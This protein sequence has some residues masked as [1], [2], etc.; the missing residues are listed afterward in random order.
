MTDRQRRC[1]GVAA[2]IAF[3]VAVGMAVLGA[4]PFA[5]QTVGPYDLL[6]ASKGWSQ[7]YGPVEVRNGERTDVLDAMVP[8]WMFARGELRQGRVP[9]WNPLPGGGEPGI[10]NL[11][12]SQLTPAFAIFAAAPSASSGFYLATLFNLVMA[13]LGAWFW[14][15]RSLGTLP[16]L[17]GGVT[18]MLCGFHAA[19]LYWPHMSTS[20]W[21]C[22]L[23]WSVE[24]W[25]KRPGAWRFA[26]MTL[27]TTLLLL[28]GFP[29]VA[30]LGLGAA[31]LYALVLWRMA[32]QPGNRRLAG[33]FGALALGA[34]L[35][36]I[37]LIALATWLAHIDT[38]A[39][40]G[41]SPLRL[42]TDAVRLLPHIARQS[43]QVESHMYV[44]GLG[45][46]LAAAALLRWI[47]PRRLEPVLVLASLLLVISSVLVF[48]LIPPAWLGWVPGLGGNGWARGILLL[49]IALAALAASALALLLRRIQRPWMAL[50]LT[51]PL[52]VV[53]VVDLGT[54]FRRFNGP[55]PAALM[56]PP[57][58]Q[59]AQVQAGLLPFTYVIADGNYLV[60]GTLGA[61][62]VPEWYG[63][64]FKTAAV[65]RLLAQAVRDPFTTPTASIIGADAIQLDSP[66][67][68]A[69]AVKYVL[70]DERLLAQAWVPEYPAGPA[71][72][73]A[74]PALGTAAWSQSVDLPAHFTLSD[75]ELRL[76]TYGGSGLHGSVTLSLLDPEK[77]GSVLA[78]AT[79]PAGSIVDG[80]M[81]RFHF[82]PAVTPAQQ[83]VVL[84]LRHEGAAANENITAWYR[85]GGAANCALQVEPA[86]APGCLILRIL[87]E[88]PGLAGWAVAAQAPGLVLLENRDAP[89]GAYFLDSLDQAPAAH[90]AEA[91]RVQGNFSD[92]WTL[93]YT[94]SRSGYVVLP[95]AAS[96]SWEFSVDGNR[97]QPQQYFGTLPAIAVQPGAVITARYQPRALIVGG[98]IMLGSVLLLVAVM[99][100][101]RRRRHAD[102]GSARGA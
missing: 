14:L 5:Q 25:W 20:V 49:D 43:P 23:L 91:V 94:G 28:G 82:A 51:V 65:K 29:F 53:Q 60:S 38:A 44:G 62:G 92:G 101:L 100:G 7:E 96:E 50:L 42:L 36:A 69:M 59:I 58:R 10:H 6:V 56:F 64:G 46:L 40:T 22:W 33:M 78:E 1:W 3:F 68:R 21:V 95:M 34:G 66:A 55:V 31:V 73:E 70:G 48:Q 80:E 37:P 30:Q 72:M 93:Q 89:A 61:Y 2:A 17:F 84:T 11:A 24:G 52:L 35:A 26:A 54:M 47:R 63:H 86:R 74:L 9:L 81:A 85:P 67:I 12:S 79:L 90:A 16:A 98:W 4:N 13:G 57:T 99:L 71:P 19:W 88:G 97:A 41:G 27:L 75:V 8:R 15:R 87:P 39:R 77:P 83:R 76:A 102:T 45:L 32:P 18:V